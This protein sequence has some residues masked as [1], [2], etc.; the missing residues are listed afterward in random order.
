MYDEPVDLTADAIVAALVR[1]W[2]IAVSKIE[3]APVGFGSY[4]WIATEQ[5]GQ[6]WFVTADSAEK[7]SGREP[8]SAFAGLEAAYATAAALRDRGLD[9]V[10]A[11][12]PDDAGQLLQRVA[13]GWVIAVFP[14]IEGKPAGKRHWDE[15]ASGLATRAAGQIGQ[16]H[17]S[18]PPPTLRR[19]DFTIEH[20]DT[21]LERLDET[22]HTGPYGEPARKLLAASREGVTALLAQY[23]QLVE[24]LLR[25]DEPWVVS[26]GE[27]HSAN[28][29][30]GNDGGLYLIDW[31]TVR[32]APK[33]RDLEAD[34]LP[35]PAIMAAYYSAAGPS[36]PRPYA[37]RLFQAWWH[38]IDTCIFV[39]HFQ[40]P[41]EHTADSQVCWREL[42]NYLPVEKN[43]PDLRTGRS[44]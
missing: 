25:D 33:E 18:P 44:K 4:H 19:F 14:Y 43:W 1:R 2:S 29:I 36:P 17:A 8:G 30:A 6:R 15:E 7:V 24:Q 42:N 12:E 40:G 37:V 11:P 10:L 13:P 35:Q 28:F 22:W 23:D 39:H 41:H 20:R 21:V 27:P 26:H 5:D 9:F 3:Y 16:L 31:D 32:L 34:W 38:L